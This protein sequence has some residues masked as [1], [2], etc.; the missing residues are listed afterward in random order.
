MLFFQTNAFSAAYVAC[1]NGTLVDGK[2]ARCG[3][4]P[5]PWL[6]CEAATGAS[7]IYMGGSIYAVG[8][9]CFLA[10][11]VTG[12]PISDLGYSIQNQVACPVSP[13]PEMTDTD[14]LAFE[15]GSRWRPDRLTADYQS[16]LACVQNAITEQGGTVTPGSAWRPTAYQAHLRAVVTKDSEIRQRA[17][18]IKDLPECAE[19][20][21]EVSA[22]MSKHSLR[23][24]QAVA[25]PG[26]SRHERGLAF[27]ITPSNVTS[28]QINTI[29][30]QCG[31]SRQAV[32]GEPW[33]FQ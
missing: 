2:F 1:K 14:A 12:G 6:A 29:A 15:A 18:E 26:L 21:S 4:G 30:Q 13:L 7:P 11:P 3:G 23:P 32:P 5:S 10:N 19:V 24:G 31:V 20:I 17:N 25:R 22:E 27:D 8:S 16:R 28:A 33:H 9:E